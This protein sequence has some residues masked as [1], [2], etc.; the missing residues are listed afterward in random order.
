MTEIKKVET[1]ALS[2]PERA[3]QIQITDHDSYEQAAEFLKSIKA[4][5]TQIEDHHKPFIKAAFKAHKEA[6]S[7]EKKFT[8]PLNIAERIIKSKIGVY[9]MEQERKRKAEIEAR[10]K[11]L[12]KAGHDDIPVEP[13]APEKPKVAG[14]STKKVL[15][16][17]VKNE[18][19]IKKEF[20][21]INTTKI[22]QLVNAMGKDAEKLVGAGSIEVYEEIITSASRG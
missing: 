6:K 2:I 21:Q 4:M 19:R 10:R 3:N 20:M 12:D 13:M 5:K 17:R 16:W 11:D 14:I 1:K 15:K 22:N 8:D 7:A 18:T 9:A